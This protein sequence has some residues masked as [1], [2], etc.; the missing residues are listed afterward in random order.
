MRRELSQRENPSLS[1]FF[2]MQYKC[3][4]LVCIGFINIGSV[5]SINIES[6]INIDRKRV[7]TSINYCARRW[8][9]LLKFVERNEWCRGVRKEGG[10]SLPLVN[11]LEEE[12]VSGRGYG[13]G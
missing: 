8:I 11:L 6:S 9:G 2:I 1:L 13:T 5:G 7:R 10:Y 3:Q 4:A 12:L